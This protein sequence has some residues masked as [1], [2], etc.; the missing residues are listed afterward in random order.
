MIQFDA[1]F[2]AQILNF[3]ILLFI[4]AKFAYKPLMKVLDERRARVANDLE[5]AEKTR[6]EAEALKEQ[7]SKQL[8]EARTEATA[9]IDKANKAGQKVHDDYVAQAQAE[10]DQMM[11]AA[12]QNIANEK[13]QAM[14]DVRAQVI[15][16]ATEIAGKVVDQKLNSAADQELVAKTADSVLNK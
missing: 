12:K 14:T 7:Y 2:F 6:V 3:L 8:A 11:A 16:L 10:K 13:D 5:T 15:A 9:I 4:L 1:T